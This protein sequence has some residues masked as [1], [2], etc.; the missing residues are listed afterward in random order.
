MNLRKADENDRK[1]IAE[2]IEKDPYHAGK[3]SADFFFEPGSECMA[4]EENGHTF[5]VRIARALRINAIFDPEQKSKNARML[6]KFTP[7]IAEMAR[8][9]GFLELVFATENPDLA[10]FEHKL[11]FDAAPGDM[12]MTLAFPEKAEV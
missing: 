4:V 8:Q 12:T 7:A 5:Y 1:R 10:K 2:L 11:G 3:G 9:S 6:I